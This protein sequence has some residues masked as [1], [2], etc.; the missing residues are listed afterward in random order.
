MAILNQRREVRFCA[1]SMGDAARTLHR[2]EAVNRAMASIGADV[3][4]ADGATDGQAE[5]A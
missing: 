2:S 1:D 5:T 3:D 4:A